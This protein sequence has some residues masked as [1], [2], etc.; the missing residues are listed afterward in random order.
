MGLNSTAAQVLITVVCRFKPEMWQV[1]AGEMGIPWRAAE[2]MHWQ[3]GEKDMAHRAGVVPF[4]L[5]SVAIEAPKKRGVAGRRKSASP[6]STTQGS[7]SPTMQG[8]GYAV[9]PGMP[10]ES[11][12]GVYRVSPGRSPEYR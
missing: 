10:S 11:E 4:S 12:R 2:A 3:L 6:A 5:S 1:I 9:G 8:A 7:A